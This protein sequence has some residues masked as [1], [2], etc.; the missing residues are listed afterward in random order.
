MPRRLIIIETNED[1][2]ESRELVN[3]LLTKQTD[4][5]KTTQAVLKAID[6]QPVVRGP[7]GPNKPKAAKQPA[8]PPLPGV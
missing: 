2:S 3:V 6:G 4:P 7:R 5:S 8:T 1:N